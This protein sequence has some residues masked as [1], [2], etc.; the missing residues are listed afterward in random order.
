MK[1]VEKIGDHWDLGLGKAFLDLTPKAL[2]VQG[3]IGKLDF[4]RIT[5]FLFKRPC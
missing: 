5:F 2:F 4:I 3:K 1:L